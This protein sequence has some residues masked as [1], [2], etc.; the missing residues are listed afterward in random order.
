[1]PTGD[2]IICRRFLLPS[3]LI[4]IFDSALAALCVSDNFEQADPAAATVSDVTIAYSLALDT[5]YQRGC[6]VVGE[7]IELAVDT[8]PSWALPCD[9]STYA[10]VDYPELASVI[11]SEFVVDGSH[12]RTPDRVN[13]FAMG[14]PPNGVQGGENAHTLTTSEMPAHTHGYIATNLP[15]AS[16]VLGVLEGFQPGPQTLQTDS[17]GGGG[18]HNNLPQYEGSTFVIVAVS[19]GT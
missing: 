2:P 19:D 3:S 11:S 1:M 4:G 13:R 8:I 6:L 9:G 15:E 5:P 7:I 16:S 17:E 14:G 18:G 12:F 10:N